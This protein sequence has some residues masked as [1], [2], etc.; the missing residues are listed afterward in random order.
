MPSTLINT[1]NQPLVSVITLIYDTPLKIIKDSI[2]SIKNN[3]YKAIQH[4]IIDDASSDQN[5]PEQ[6]QQ[7]LDSLSYECIFIRH[8]KNQGIVKSVNEAFRHCK[9]KYVFHC[10]DDVFLNNRIQHD[11]EVFER[12][13]EEYAAL[14][15]IAQIID[16]NNIKKASL[17]PTFS[18]NHNP[19]E[20]NQ[21]FMYNPIC[22]PATTLRLKSIQEV[23]YYDEQF[24]FE[25]YPMWFK[26]LQNKYKFKFSPEINTLYRKHSQ[27][28]SIRKRSEVIFESFK[29][30]L[31][32]AKSP[33]DL[34]VVK[35]GVIHYLKYPE[36]QNIVEICKL[37]L[38][39]EYSTLFKFYIFLSRLPFFNSFLKK[40]F[41]KLLRFF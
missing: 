22:A 40:L 32:F 7:W 38:M 12:L 26:L 34:K 10:S 2:L 18:F 21:L 25:D 1:K 35:N 9:G 29:I 37:Y 15:S 13:P 6:I 27:S 24:M 8:K 19:E 31:H 23:G 4:I 41:A 16:E 33:K 36:D 17:F 11:V 3:S 28:I 20:L 5:L 14:F 30:K 39:Y